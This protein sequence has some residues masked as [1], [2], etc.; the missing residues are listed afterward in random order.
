[1]G[2]EWAKAEDIGLFAPETVCD[3]QGVTRAG[4]GDTVVWLGF[5]FVVFLYFPG[6]LG[7]EVQFLLI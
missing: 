1:M 4:H 2:L 6:L 5:D 3:K 7:V